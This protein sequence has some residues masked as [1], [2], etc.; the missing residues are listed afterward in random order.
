MFKTGGIRSLNSSFTV[1]SARA[2]S[3]S[4]DIGRMFSVDFQS[5]KVCI[6]HREDDL[7]TFGFLD[8]P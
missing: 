7:C 3:F 1:S 2:H 4:E 6:R 5:A 8:F